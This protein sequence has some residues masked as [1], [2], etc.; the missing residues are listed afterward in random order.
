MLHPLGDSLRRLHL[1]RERVCDLL[2]SRRRRHRHDYGP[3]AHH[4]SKLPRVGRYLRGVFRIW[5]ESNTIR[6][7][8][9]R[10][11]P[12]QRVREDF[13]HAG[14]SRP[15]ENVVLWTFTR[16]NLPLRYSTASSNTMFS[17]W[18][19][20]LRTPETERKRTRCQC[21]ATSFAAR[22]R[23]SSRHPCRCGIHQHR[24]K[25]LGRGY[26]LLTFPATRQFHVDA[27]VHELG[28]LDGRLLRHDAALLL[29]LP[30]PPL[31]RPSRCLAPSLRS[32]GLGCS[33]WQIG[34]SVRG[35]V[36]VLQ[37]EGALAL[38]GQG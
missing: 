16:G 2:D 36:R 11:R 13:G 29:R 33:N 32:R 31:Q 15:G 10:Q 27:L 23:A 9:R 37:K 20:P 24:L 8:R 25:C 26:A 7:M 21:L 1:R 38:V 6:R 4:E 5:F 3:A 22:R 12:G 28:Q 34:P 18:S 30:F 19:Y 35:R 17:S 14:G